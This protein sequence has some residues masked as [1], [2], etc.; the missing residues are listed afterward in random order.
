[1]TTLDV[2]AAFARMQELLGVEIDVVHCPHAAGPPKCW[3]RK[4][5]PGLGVLL[6]HRHQLDAP[7][8]IYVAAGAQDPDSRGASDSSI[9]RQPSSSQSRSADRFVQLGVTA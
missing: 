4:P 9:K 2:D 7:Q 8:C 6:I 3:C 5:L 1:M